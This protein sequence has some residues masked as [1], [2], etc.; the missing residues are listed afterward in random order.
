MTLPYRR[1]MWWKNVKVLIAIG[2]SGVVSF[3]GTLALT[4]ADPFI[5]LQLL[6]YVI[7]ASMCG[8]GLHCTS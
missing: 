7:T 2:F 6:L 1:K 8:I 5:T 3:D 4:E